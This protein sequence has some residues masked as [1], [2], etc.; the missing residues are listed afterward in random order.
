[1]MTCPSIYDLPRISPADS[2]GRN[3][4]PRPSDIPA[5]TQRISPPRHRAGKGSSCPSATAPR[6]RYQQSRAC[7]TLQHHVSWRRSRSSRQCS[8]SGAF[9]PAT[10]RHWSC[11]RNVWHQPTDHTTTISTCHSSNPECST[12]ADHHCRYR[13][14]PGQFSHPCRRSSP[15]SPGYSGSS[16]QRASA[17][18]LLR[19][20]R[21]HH[22]ATLR[23]RPSRGLS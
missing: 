8:L 13:R 18:L 12:G 15:C 11:S 23:M 17:R 1:M 9:Q 19:W 6:R 4:R 16:H 14:Q 3:S 21:R 22:S 10:T 20:S 2:R 7:D 5:P